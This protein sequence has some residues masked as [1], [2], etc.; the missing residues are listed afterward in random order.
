MRLPTSIIWLDEGGYILR[1]ALEARD[2]RI[3]PDLGLL[4]GNADC[5]DIALRE[6]ATPD[7]LFWQES[8][9]QDPGELFELEEEKT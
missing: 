9:V 5:L 7:R 8:R 2:G 3:S 4:P 6:I 1:Y